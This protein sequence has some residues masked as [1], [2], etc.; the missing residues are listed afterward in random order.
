MALVVVVHGVGQ[1]L[2]GELTLHNRFF[3]ALKQGVT[4]ADGAIGPDDVVF[5]SY[6]EFF[7]PAAEVL[8][9]LPYF[10]EES[11][12]EGATNRWPK[13][14]LCRLLGR[15]RAAGARDAAAA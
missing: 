11:V 8:S 4:R 9:P 10:D 5:A 2:E 14:G 3:S 7:R 13:G 12:E 15:S 1:Q 6:G